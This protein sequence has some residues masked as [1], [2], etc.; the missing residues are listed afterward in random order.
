[1][2][3]LSREFLLSPRRVPPFVVEN[4]SRSAAPARDPRMEG[5]GLKLHPDDARRGHPVPPNRLVGVEKAPDVPNV[6]L[7]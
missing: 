7:V 5:P 6:D 4:L 2:T 3:Y 1:M